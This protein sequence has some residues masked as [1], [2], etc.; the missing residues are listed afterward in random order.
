[1]VDLQ[2]IHLNL[3]DRR[4]K[5]NTNLIAEWQVTA[6]LWLACEW[7]HIWAHTKAGVSTARIPACTRSRHCDTSIAHLAQTA[8]HTL[9]WCPACEVE[10]CLRHPGCVR[11]LKPLPHCLVSQWLKHRNAIFNNVEQTLGEQNDEENMTA[12]NF[13]LEIYK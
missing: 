12:M 3:W 9:K 7:C 8:N 6:G 2:A 13:L 11:Y 10:L 4:S 1:M 5:E